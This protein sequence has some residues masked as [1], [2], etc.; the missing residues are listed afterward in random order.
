MKHHETDI[1]QE[2]LTCVSSVSLK[3][4]AMSI[5]QLAQR[6][7]WTGIIYSYNHM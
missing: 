3:K 2:H 6:T 5:F 7:Q 4:T 1:F